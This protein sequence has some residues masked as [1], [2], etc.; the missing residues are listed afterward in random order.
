[1]PFYAY[2]PPNNITTA[3]IVGPV[4]VLQGTTPWVVGGTVN[5]IIVPNGTLKNYFNET[6]AVASGV[7]TTLQT[8]TVIAPS[9]TLYEINVTGTNIA[10]YTVLLNSVT[11]AQE[12]TYFGGNLDEIF[13][14]SVGLPLVTGDVVQVKVIHNRP[15]VGDF[16]S[17][18]LVAET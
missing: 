18:I 4:T 5:A 12:L 6:L 2:Y 10:K 15:S 13:S 9:A 11:I 1:M 8:Y 7:L 14:F 16:T 17:R 3:T